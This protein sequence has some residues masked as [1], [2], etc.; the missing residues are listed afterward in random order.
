MK[1]H[2][3]LFDAELCSSLRR[4]SVRFAKTHD[5]QTQLWLATKK[6]QL[7]AFDKSAAKSVAG[8]GDDYCNWTMGKGAGGRVSLKMSRCRI[9][10]E[11]SLSYSHIR[12]N[13][14][15]VKVCH[16]SMWRQ[17]LRKKDNERLLPNDES[18][19]VV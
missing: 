19:F 13:P 17:L 1:Y 6:A 9:W 7:Q 10:C 8:C 12:L 18:S 16:F 5:W 2:Y 3:H 11:H 14:N 4:V 15:R